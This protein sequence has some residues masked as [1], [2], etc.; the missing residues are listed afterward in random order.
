MGSDGKL[1]GCVSKKGHLTVLKRGNTKCAKGQSA[2]AWNQTGPAG[3]QGR[4]GEQGPKGDR[5][6]PG[7]ATGAAGGDL[8]G[9][10]PNPT[11]SPG[12]K[13]AAGDTPSL[14]SLG[15]GPSRRC[16]ATPHRVRAVQ[17]LAT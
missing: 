2:I 13:D 11:L 14:R 3:Q 12:L 16:P 17:R 5:G 10:Y 1:H 8:T 4:D 15:G 6:D 9:S 7:P